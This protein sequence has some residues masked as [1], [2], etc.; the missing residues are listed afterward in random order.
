MQ[1]DPSPSALSVDPDDLAACQ[2]L[3]AAGSKS[4]AL[5]SKLLPRRVRD[6]ATVLY[7]F[8]RVADDAVDADPNASL[9]TVDVLRSRLD[10]MCAGTPDADPIDRALSVVM[11]E[12]SLPRIYVDA[13]LEGLAWDAQGRVYETLDDLYAYA[14]RVAGAVGTAMTILMGP[15][16][17]HVLARALDLGIA[18]QLTNIARDVHEDAL[19]KRIYLPLA[20]MREANIDVEA[21][22]D[23]PTESDALRAVTRRLLRHADRLYRRADAGISELPRDC[24]IA[25][26]AARLIYSDIGNV[27]AA[28]G[29]QTMTTSRAVVPTYRKL[30]LLARASGA[31]FWRRLRHEAPAVGPARFLV[32]P[33]AP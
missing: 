2:R 33:G 4:F 5:A 3:L 10:R 24:R 15:R 32:A 9:E 12:T 1:P 28:R 25:I 14:A 27:I 13:L 17:P 18:M 20:W 7:A 23:Q 19:R 6:P 26:R 22:L 30:W 29:F 8:C 16:E 21:W 11:Q 31:I